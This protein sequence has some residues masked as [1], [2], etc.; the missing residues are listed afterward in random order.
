MTITK[1]FTGFLILNWKTKEVKVRKTKPYK[2]SDSW[3]PIKYNINLGLP[4]DPVAEIKGDL[5]LPQ[6]RI[7]KLVLDAL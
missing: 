5:V 2:L 7:E 6:K 1:N 4:D 3:I